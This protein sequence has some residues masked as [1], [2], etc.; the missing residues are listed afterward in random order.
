[1]HLISLNFSF[2]ICKMRIITSIPSGGSKDYKKISLSY[3]RTEFRLGTLP[4]YV[5]S[6]KVSGKDSL[7]LSACLPLPQTLGSLKSNSAA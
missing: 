3:S 5:P 2:P 6:W 4:T 1:M 7:K